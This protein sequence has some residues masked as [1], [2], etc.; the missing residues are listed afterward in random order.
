LVVQFFA[1]ITRFS[2]T[3]FG[4]MLLSSCDLS[5]QKEEDNSPLPFIILADAGQSVAEVWKSA[6]G[7][8]ITTGRF[9]PGIQLNRWWVKTLVKNNSDADGEFFLILNNPHIN[10]LEVFLDKSINASM[11]TGDRFPF[12]SRPYPS[13]DFVIPIQLKSGESKEILMNLDKRGETFHIDPEILNAKEYDERRRNEHLIMGIVAGW[14]ALILVI[15]VFFWFELRHRSAF[16]YAVFVLSVFLWIFSH[17]G[18][19][20][21]YLWPES[22]TWVGKSRPVFNLASNIALLLTVVNFFPPT[23]AQNR[24]KIIL[25][26]L[27]WINGLLLLAFLIIPE[28]AVEL[29]II[30]FFLKVVLVFSA[31]QILS[32]L[33]YLIVKYLSKTPFS[34]F[35]LAGILFLFSFSMLVF[36]DQVFGII[37]LSHYLLNFGS[38][39][40]TMGE[41]GLIA[42]A[43]I[44]QASQEKKVKEKLVIK[45]LEKEKDSANQVILA[46]EEERNR[47]G[48]DLHDGLLGYLTGVHLKVQLIL[49]KN[50]DPE[51][52]ELKNRILEGIKETR[53][54]SHNLTPPF[55]EELGLEKALENQLS[56]IHQ[57]GILQTTL[58]TKIESEISKPF[59]VNIY[60]ICMELIS[61]AIKHSEASEL[62][63]SLTTTQK[64]LQLMVEDDGI[65]FDPQ[66]A[67]NGIGLKNMHNRVQY[68]KGMLQID[69]NPSGTSILILIPLTTSGYDKN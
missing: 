34:G 24:W 11:I 13:R 39:F 28:S 42:F 68:L 62:H 2:F 67:V 60:R 9:N 3:L 41:T 5:A 17:W 46:Q 69:S 16:Y 53:V 38:A 18:M 10:Y 8:T 7:D 33:G 57:S 66:V 61:N 65:G 14:I 43:F 15:T 26:G 30:S 36:F 12:D 49:D 40:G 22:V 4:L 58:Y 21:Q 51:L 25:R 48:R 64:E 1:L 59:Q 37:K 63:V 20:F 44:R 32:I 52:I 19:G 55:L 47:L 45:I 29:V 31:I 23:L 35:Y 54:L 27:I 50:P 6:K 56:T